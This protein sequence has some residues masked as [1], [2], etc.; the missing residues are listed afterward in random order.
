ML[1][2]IAMIQNVEKP[3]NLVKVFHQLISPSIS[4]LVAYSIHEE[5]PNSYWSFKNTHYWLLTKPK[6]TGEVH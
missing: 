6:P 1:K 5:T 4:T 3:L 2:V